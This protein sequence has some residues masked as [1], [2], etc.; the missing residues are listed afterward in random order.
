M[1]LMIKICGLRD[2]RAIGAAIDAGANAVGFVFAESVRRIDPA[3][4][5]ELA[6]GL[7]PSIKRVA[8]MRHPEV[9]LWNS[10]LEIFQPQVVQTDVSDFEYLDVPPG[11]ETWPVY[12]EGESLE[13]LP[14]RFVYE[15]GKSGSGQTVDWHRAAE[16]AKRGEMILA[17]GLKPENI[18]AAIRTVRPYGVD[19]SSGVESA[20][21]VKDVN[22]IRAFIAAARAAETTG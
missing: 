20:P 4:A 14:A 12:R 13:A 19:V 6:A 22:R 2:P 11:I 21:G 9:A 5:A 1:S 15:G 17:G 3:E 18:A 8:V 16:I 7:P 10:V